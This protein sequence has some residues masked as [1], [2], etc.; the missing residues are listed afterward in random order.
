MLRKGI[1]LKPGKGLK[2][3]SETPVS[4]E[5]EPDLGGG[6]LFHNTEIQK[7][8]ITDTFP[9][10]EVPWSMVGDGAGQQ[11]YFQRRTLGSKV[12]AVKYGQ[13]K[14]F[15]SEVQFLNKYWDSEIVPVPRIVYI[16]A[17]PGN[18]IHFLAK[19]FP[20]AKFYLY[21]TQPFDERLSTLPNVKI[22]QSYFEQRDVDAYKNRSDIFLISD[23]RS[24]GYDKS[25]KN[26]DVERANEKL[27]DDDMRLQMKWVQEIKPVKALLKFKLPYS[28][29]WNKEKSY[30]YLDGDVWKQPFSAVTSTECRLVPDMN[31]LNRNWDFRLYEKQMFYHNNIVREK[32]KFINPLTNINE[33]ISTDL[34]LTQD[35]DSSAFVFVIKEYLMKFNAFAST[36]TSP[37]AVLKLCEAII[38]DI[39][40]GSVNLKML[41]SGERNDAQLIAIQKAMKAMNDQNEE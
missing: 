39:S 2:L 26:E 18:H 1:Q 38:Q 23:I 5:P 34:G 19:M 30:N 31:P 33:D 17:S 22:Y 35:Y 8:K 7:G 28:Y 37:D 40:R 14:L 11:D 27:A 24:L 29:A 9:Y 16:G 41:R 13:L 6:A 15:I 3:K 21:D 36:D 10:K 32:V 12:T 20:M 4:T 25:Q